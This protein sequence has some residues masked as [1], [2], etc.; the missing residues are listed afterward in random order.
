M[1]TGSTVSGHSNIT[2]ANNTFFSAASGINIGMYFGQDLPE[3]VNVI[4]NTFT[5]TTNAI[6]LEGYNSGVVPLEGGKNY[7]ISENRIAGADKG[8]T[9]TIVSYSYAKLK[10]KNNSFDVFEYGLDLVC[11]GSNSPMKNTRILNNNVK[12]ENIVLS[13]RYFGGE[14]LI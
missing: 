5:N 2:V 13:M 9:G 4:Y 10:I 1:G 3:N 11:D 8:I 6:T 12:T 7:L 14:T